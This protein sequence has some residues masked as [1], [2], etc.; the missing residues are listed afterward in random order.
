MA[1][2]Y[3]PKGKKD[4]KTRSE[5]SVI[6][7]T[8]HMHKYMKGRTFKKR[9]P[10]ATKVVR[11]IAKQ[12]MG[13]EDNR[14]EVRLNK[15]IWSKGIK[16]CPT[17]IRVRLERKR[18]EDEDAKYPLYTVASY[19]RLPRDGFKGLCTKVVSNDEE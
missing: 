9:A 16:G 1:K 18:N 17:R 8:I 4:R 13:T 7:T 15:A 5:T 11:K 10:F 19:V 6:D 12:V 3:V 2:A 14:I